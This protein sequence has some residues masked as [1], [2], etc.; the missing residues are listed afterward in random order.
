MKC[1]HFFRGARTLLLMQVA[2]A[3]AEIPLAPPP[4]ASAPP[5]DVVWVRYA[6]GSC[7]GVLEIELFERATGRWLSHPLHPQLAPGACAEEAPGGLLNELR[8]RC[9][10]PAG[11]RAPS[12]WV[13]GAELASA[14]GSSCKA[15]Q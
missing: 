2:F 5:P 11:A 8:V 15:A 10:D 12:E 6:A 13:V 1:S 9:A 4:P 3:C 14:A 7:T